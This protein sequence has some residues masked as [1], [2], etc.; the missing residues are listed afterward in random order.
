MNWEMVSVCLT[1]LVLVLQLWNAYTVTGL[2]YWV[3][4]NFVAKEEIPNY[5]GP[6]N[7]RLQRV[8]SDLRLR[9]EHSRR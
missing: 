1:A 4:K 3:T 2:K 7:N 6:I 5:I 8:E 9:T